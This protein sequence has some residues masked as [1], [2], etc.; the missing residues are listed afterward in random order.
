[1]AIDSQLDPS[2]NYPVLLDPNTTQFEAMGTTYYVDREPRLSVI[3]ERFLEKFSLYSMLGRSPGE[4]INQLTDAY[5]AINTG[6]IG[7]AAVKIDNL[8][9]GAKEL[10]NKTAPVYY[11]CTLFMNRAGEDRQTYTTDDAERKIKDWEDAGL[12]SRFFLSAGL[13]WL[14]ATASVNLQLTQSYAELGIPD[15]PDLQLPGRV[16]SHP[17]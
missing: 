2:G 3:R 7:D 8:L 16:S 15:L 10:E 6:K 4:I 11:I 13:A 1:M 12:D 9:R 14:R 5:S 17:A